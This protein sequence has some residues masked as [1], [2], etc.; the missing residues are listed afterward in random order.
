MTPG[1]YILNNIATGRCKLYSR[2]IQWLLAASYDAE[3]LVDEWRS[4]DAHIKSNMQN[5]YKEHLCNSM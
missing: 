1:M 5:N 4:N 3:F 2:K